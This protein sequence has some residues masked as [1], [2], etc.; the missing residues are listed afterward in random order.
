MA[1]LEQQLDRTWQAFSAIEGDRLC[2]AFL[3]NLRQGNLTLFNRFLK[4]ISEAMIDAALRALAAAI[5]AA[6]DPQQPLMSDLSQVRLVS[7]A[8]AAA[9]AWAAVG[10]GLDRMATTE[11]EAIE[12]LDQAAWKPVYGPVVA[13]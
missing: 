12:R 7:R 13:A 6:S 9:G 4:E 1:T 5:A 8:L 11:T 2:F 3:A 10:E